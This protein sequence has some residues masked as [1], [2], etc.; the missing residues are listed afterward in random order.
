MTNDDERMMIGVKGSPPGWLP[1]APLQIY[2][3]G[4]MAANQLIY[5]FI[6]MIL[7]I[8]KFHTGAKGL[9]LNPENQLRS[10]WLPD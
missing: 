2:R 9:K 4:L 3:S 1:F 7:V 6:F 10:E 8:S 5:Q